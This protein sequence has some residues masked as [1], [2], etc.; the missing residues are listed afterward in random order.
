MRD[1]KTKKLRAF[2]K[3]ITSK[4]SLLL[5]ASLVCLAPTPSFANPSQA[6]KEKSDCLENPTFLTPDSQEFKYCLQPDGTYKT[7]NQEG[8]YLKK[9]FEIDKPFEERKHRQFG[10]IQIHNCRIE[11]HH[12][13]NEQPTN[14]T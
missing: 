5:M 10:L 13:L 14:I 9:E 7:I 3:I 6:F 11:I 1:Y 4:R 12:L 2:P 8:S